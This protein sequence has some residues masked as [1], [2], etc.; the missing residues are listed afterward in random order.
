MILSVE[1]LV[2][3]GHMPFYFFNVFLSIK[4]KKT[5]TTIQKSQILLIKNGKKDKGHITK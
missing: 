1:Y 3:V 4:K 5:Q 2:I